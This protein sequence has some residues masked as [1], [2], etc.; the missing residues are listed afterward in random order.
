M[1]PTI[2][3]FWN[4]FQNNQMIFSQITY[5]D[6]VTFAPHFQEITNLLHQ[7]NPNLELIFRAK[8]KYRLI[9]TAN[10]KSKHFASARELVKHAP[11]LDN[12]KIIALVPR[13][14]N[15][16]KFYDE[17]DGNFLYG[18]V[19]FRISQCY[20]SLIGLKFSHKIGL[21][22][23]L[24]NYNDCPNT[25]RLHEAVSIAVEHLIGERLFSKHI[26]FIKIGQLNDDQEEVLQLHELYDFIA[27]LKREKLL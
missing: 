16:N 11:Q 13:K 7:Y 25:I 2:T 9:V 27:S 17:K 14:K 4:H 1:N 10:R 19:K 20:F 8:N 12:W 3:N 5:F 18:T 6:P 21:E 26:K 15:L 22:V 24:P 23:H